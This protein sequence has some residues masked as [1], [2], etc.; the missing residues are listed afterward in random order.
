MF[1]AATRTCDGPA[2]AR[3][4]RGVLL[5]PLA[6]AAL[7]ALFVAPGCAKRVAL[8]PEANIADGRRFEIEFEG[9][10]ALRGRLVS[11]SNVRYVQGDSLFRAEVGEVTDEFIE[12]SR[13]V[14]LIDLKEWSPLRAA[15]EDAE[16]VNGRPELGGALLPRDEIQ[17]VSVLTLDRRR[18]VTEAV[19]WTALMIAAGFAGTGR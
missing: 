11:G 9:E 5:A 12:L 14:F 2:G 1:C 19:F 17:S 13:R 3:P 15:E 16:Q 6:L 4:R 8:T 18:M 7:A 10:R